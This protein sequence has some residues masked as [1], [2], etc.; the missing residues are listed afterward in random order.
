MECETGKNFEWN[1]TRMNRTITGHF[2]SI[3][4]S[5]NSGIWGLVTGRTG[6]IDGTIRSFL[7]SL[8]ADIL[9]Q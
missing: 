3:E 5:V 9:V 1:C 4:I 2:Q 6:D 7:T 8:I